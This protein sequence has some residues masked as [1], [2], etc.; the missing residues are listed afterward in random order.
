MQFYV[1]DDDGNVAEFLISDPVAV[2][3]KMDAGQ[4]VILSRQDSTVQE[5]CD[6]VAAQS[7]QTAL[8]A[9]LSH[10]SND[11]MPSTAAREKRKKVLFG[12]A[13]AACRKALNQP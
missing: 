2:L 3:A 7:A 1:L 10:L 6:L 13:M 12:K 11:Q 9:F 8:R 4:T 5:R